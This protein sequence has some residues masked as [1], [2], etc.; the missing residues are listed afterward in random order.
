MQYDGKDKDK[1]SLILREILQDISATDSN[2]LKILIYEPDKIAELAAR[3]MW[4]EAEN[5]RLIT[6]EARY[7]MEMYHVLDMEDK[8]KNLRKFLKEKD[9][10]PPF[11]F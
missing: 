9:I 4:L 2:T 7:G 3:N 5:A 6:V 1:V 10:Y 8:I 11:K